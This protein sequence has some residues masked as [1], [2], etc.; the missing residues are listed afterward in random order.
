MYEAASA[1]L[2]KIYGRGLFIEFCLPLLF[3]DSPA[4]GGAYREG[5]PGR[6]P[7]SPAK[8]KDWKRL[9]Y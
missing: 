6:I 7:P 4:R 5:L 1:E 3:L 8:G 2:Q 9:D